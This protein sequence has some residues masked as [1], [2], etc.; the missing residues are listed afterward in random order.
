MCQVL[1]V[2]STACGAFKKAT[3]D[4]QEPGSTGCVSPQCAGQALSDAQVRW[5]VAADTDFHDVPGHQLRRRH[6]VRSTNDS[7]LGV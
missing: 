3:L 7:V 4:L 2:H 6:P 5:H 1:A